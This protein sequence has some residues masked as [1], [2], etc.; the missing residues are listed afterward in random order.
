MS[1][2]VWLT[3]MDIKG[4]G[5]RNVSIPLCQGLSEKGYDVKIIGLQYKGQEHFDPFSIIPARNLQESF[6]MIHNFREMW[7]FDELIVALDIPIQEVI[8]A[9]FPD[10]KFKYTGIFPIESD[11]LIDTWALLLQQMDRQFIISRF[12]TEEAHKAGVESVEYIEI[13]V[14]TESWRPPTDE[15]REQIRTSFGLSSNTFSVLTV[16]DNQERKHLSRSM[17]IFADFLYNHSNVNRKIIEEKN[18]VPKVDARYS[19]VTREHNPVGW[20]LRDYARYLGISAQFMLFE[21]GIEFDKF[22]SLYAMSDAF[23]LTSKAEGLG[24]PILE[25]MA[26]GLPCI[27][28]NCT[29]IAEHL[30]NKRG[31]LIDVDYVHVDPFGNGNRYFASRKHG[32]ELLKKLY[33]G[34]KPNIANAVKYAQERKWQYAVDKLHGVLLL[35]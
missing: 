31:Y 6:A 7:G 23:L 4:S 8:L 25:A 28:T 29:G 27:G 10:R 2:V 1:K 32:V 21:R 30:C 20:Q 26:V 19:L 18:L 12:G 5:Y 11:P 22:W 3:D 15:E 33:R 14:D 34:R 35:K 13:G 17:E 24:M 9:T 16:A